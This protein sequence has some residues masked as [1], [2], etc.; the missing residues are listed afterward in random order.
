MFQNI[1]IC[2]KKIFI[3][4]IIILF[5]IFSS[6]CDRNIQGTSIKGAA[7]DTEDSISTKI[8]YDLNSTS[9]ESNVS[10]C[11][12]D[13]YNG[14]QPHICGDE[15]G[16]YWV[17]SI[18]GKR[19]LV[20]LDY[21]KSIAYPLDT[22]MSQDYLSG[23]IICF[24]DKIISIKPSSICFT[25]LLGNEPYEIIL[26]N[27]TTFSIG[28]IVRCDNSLYMLSNAETFDNGLP[29]LYR[30][31]TNYSI[32]EVLEIDGKYNSY[33]IIG[34]CNFGLI[35][36]AKLVNT[37]SFKVIEEQN[38][39]VNP[40]ENPCMLVE[41]NKE[42]HGTTIIPFGFSD[43]NSSY[44]FDE[45]KNTITEIN[46]NTGSKNIT[47]WNRNTIKSPAYASN[48]EGFLVTCEYSS[49]ET[50]GDKEDALVQYAFI[51]KA[52]YLAHNPNY[53]LFDYVHLANLSKE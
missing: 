34:F 40:N 43:S 25:N 3:V 44:Y 28:Q 16:A 35:I 12:V 7:I 1:L 4:G 17:P 33:E 32:E 38:F 50:F 26:P 9:T 14:L 31:N 24:N 10:Y 15:N 36:W 41:Y 22:N 39:V 27:S 11:I 13:Y 53:I 49:I 46:L 37:N 2:V 51:S 45:Y 21:N 18:N 23:Q 29:M 42:I 30:I 19:Y 20:L 8:E 52:D 5:T 6:C 47:Q 48:A